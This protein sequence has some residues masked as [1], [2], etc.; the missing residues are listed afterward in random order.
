M[1]LEG[2][3]LEEALAAAPNTIT[4][5]ASDGRRLRSI[6][7]DRVRDVLATGQFVCVGVCGRIDH[8]RPSR[9]QDRSLR[10]LKSNRGTLSAED[11][12][13]TS[14]IAGHSAYR[15]KVTKAFS[16]E[17]KANTKPNSEN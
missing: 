12:K 14:G 11:S 16:P 17:E 3:V 5:R 13:H 4:V 1:I 6:H 10:G 15:D 8:L 2:A 9:L 7:S